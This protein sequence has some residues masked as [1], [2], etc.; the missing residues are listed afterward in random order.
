M[1]VGIRGVP[2]WETELWGY[3]G[4]GDGTR[5]PMYGC[6]RHRLSGG[7]C[8]SD[9]LNHI[10]RLLDDSQINISKYSSIGGTAGKQYRG[11][12]F[13]LVERMA[14]EYI[15]RAGAR[16]P[17]VPA[18][19]VSMFDEQH[20]IEIHETALKAY[21]GGVWNLRDKWVIQLKSD[22]ST[23]AKRFTVF[24]EAFHILA[25][26]R[27]TPMFRQRHRK[28]GL[29]NELL[30]N[31]FAGCI[32]MPRKWVKERWV[33]VKNLDRMAEIFDVEKSLMWIRLR[34]IGLI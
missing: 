17:P 34:E 14:E 28:T 24:H 9:N 32:L 3:L 19:I 18:E 12:V 8:P 29:F 21:H 7:W 5:C 2:K 20:R 16:C 22:D 15:K 1:T 6:C 25:H 10:N 13:Q 30:A 33:E 26:D 23:A 4:I 11:R 31:Y 27:A